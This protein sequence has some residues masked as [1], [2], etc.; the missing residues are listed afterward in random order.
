MINPYFCYTFAFLVVLLAYP[1]GWSELYPPLSWGLVLFLSITIALHLFTGK[2]FLKRCGNPFRKLETDHT[3]TPAIWMTIFLCLLWFAEFVY[4]GGVPLVKILWAHP[5][6]Y[7]LFGIPTLHVFI[8]TF[9]SF[10][11]IYLFHLYLSS[12]QRLHLALFLLNLS[13][14][15]LIYSRAMFFFNVSACLFMYLIQVR[16]IPRV[17]PYVAIVALMI[18][19]YLF[20]VMGTLRVSREA[21]TPYDNAHFLDIGKAE[22]SFVESPIPEEYFWTYIYLTSP[23]ANLQNNI[24]KYP[25]QPITLRRVGEMINNEILMDFISKRVNSRLQVDREK[26]YT[27]PGPFNVSTVYSRCYSY[28]GWTGMVIMAAVVL[29]VPVVYAKLVP[30]DS[31]FFLTGF[32]TLCTMFLFLG[33]DNTVRLTGLSFQVVYPIV[34]HFTCKWLPH[35]KKIF[36]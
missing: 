11:T 34:L 17:V 9:S 5:Y 19:L 25:V 27:I 1:L 18:V 15:V 20:G 6:N 32:V 7:R 35:V 23:L 12:R 3:G 4:E 2:R 24:D 26:E 14:A 31:P 10:Y 13:A 36:L 22:T 30:I 33:Y 16:R 8:V 21:G 29:L 28:L